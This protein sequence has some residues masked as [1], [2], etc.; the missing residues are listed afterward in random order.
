[1][2]GD[3]RHGAAAAVLVAAAAVAAIAAA[4]VAVKMYARSRESFVRNEDLDALVLQLRDAFPV[5]ERLNF[6]EGDKSYTINKKDVYICMRDE[7]GAYYD[8]NFLTYVMLHEISHAL[9]DEIGHTPK[10]LAIFQQVQDRAAALGVF[11]PHGKK[12]HNYCN[13]K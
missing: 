6:Y 13:Y 9:C 5:V 4:A 3:Y 8:R 2:R 7:H 11:D 1:M 12:I 10:F